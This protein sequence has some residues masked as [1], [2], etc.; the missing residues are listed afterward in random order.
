[1]IKQIWKYKVENV[2]EMPIDAEI[3]SVQIQ[4]GQMFNACIWAKVNPENE[5]EKR[6]FVVI[7]TGH[8]FDDS[9]MEYIG[10]YQDGPFV[11]HL[12]EVKTNLDN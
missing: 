2:I 6:Q 10:T 9:D 5:L 7:G 4:N 11:W 8:T 3:L 12:F 1:M